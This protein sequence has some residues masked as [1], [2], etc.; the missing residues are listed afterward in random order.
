MSQ[1]EASAAMGVELVADEVFPDEESCYWLAAKAESRPKLLFMMSYDKVV[2][3]DVDDAAIRTVASVGI[4]STEEAV[5]A[6]YGER[7]SVMPHHYTDGHY[8]IVSGPDGLKLLFETDG[9]KV[10]TFR[11]GREPEVSYVEGCS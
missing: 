5:R 8:L 10:T 1:K 2:R 9:S 3:Y 4:G 11:S 7:I 6:A